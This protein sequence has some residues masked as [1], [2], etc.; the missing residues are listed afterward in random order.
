M[1][2]VSRYSHGMLLLWQQQQ[3]QEQVFNEP[4]RFIHAFGIGSG[5]HVYTIVVNT[6]FEFKPQ[7]KLSSFE[8]KIQFK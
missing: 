8:F 1:T 5:V 4:D 6:L 3:K 2:S 7:F